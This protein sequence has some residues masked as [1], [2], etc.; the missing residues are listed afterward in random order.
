MFPQLKTVY[1]SSS[2]LC[3]QAHVGVGPGQ[4]LSCS[5]SAHSRSKIHLEAQ[6]GLLGRWGLA[7]SHCG[8]KNT[9]R[10]GT[11]KRF[12]ALLFFFSVSFCSVV[13][14]VVFIMCYFYIYLK[15]FFK[16]IF[17]NFFYFY[18]TLLLF[19]GFFLFLFFAFNFLIFLKF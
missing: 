16:Y 5:H 4:S 18:F 17:L 8:S 12:L 15:K 19:C 6:E 14:G 7:V 13:A 1:V 11:R 2:G 3:G 9:A 10:G